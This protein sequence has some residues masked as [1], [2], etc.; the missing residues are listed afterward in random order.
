MNQARAT[1]FTFLALDVFT[2]IAVFNIVRYFRGGIVAEHFILFP[3]I[4]PVAV[5]LFSIYLIDGYN[6]RTDMLS[7][8]YTSQHSIAII[9]TMLATLLFLF[10]F[11]SEGSQLQSS[12]MVIVV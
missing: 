11:I 12:R 1:A 2:A 10:A 4:G 9:S 8:D 6:T 3:L 5:I 7:V